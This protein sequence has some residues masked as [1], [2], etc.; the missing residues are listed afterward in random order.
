MIKLNIRDDKNQIAKTYTTEEV[1]LKM[2]TVEDIIEVVNI[3]KLINNADDTAVNLYDVIA[4]LM[5]N[6]YK[7]CK[8]IIKDIFPEITE[9]E[10]R[11]VNF[12]DVISLVVDIIRYSISDINTIFSAEKN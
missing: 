6:S 9:E 10:L 2:G 7:L 11:N 8:P 12:K 3:D 1:N 5:T 4:S